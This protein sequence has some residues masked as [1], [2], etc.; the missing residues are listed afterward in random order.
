MPEL[1]RQEVEADM[2]AS[3]VRDDVLLRWDPEVDLVCPEKKLVE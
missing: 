3:L 1:A 2:V